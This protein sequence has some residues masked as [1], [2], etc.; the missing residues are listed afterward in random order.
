[1]PTVL[2]QLELIRDKVE[3]LLLPE[4]ESANCKL[5]VSDDDLADFGRPS[6]NSQV[7]FGLSNM[8]LQ[9]PSGSGALS[10]RGFNAQSVSLNMSFTIIAKQLWNKSSGCYAIASV[11]VDRLNGQSLDQT[12]GNLYFSSLQV[13]GRD[14]KDKLW[15][16][17]LV[18]TLE[19]KLSPGSSGPVASTVSWG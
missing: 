15:T 8:S 5:V 13:L 7:V 19:T 10:Q 1:M 6:R 2:D 9:A 12:Y 3:A 16:Y 14:P 11:I 18:A 4:L 17:E